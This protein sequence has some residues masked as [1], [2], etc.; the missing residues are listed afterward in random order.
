MEADKKNYSEE[1]EIDINV[2]GGSFK[3]IIMIHL[4]RIA[5]LSSTELRGGYFSV[6]QTKD[7]STKEIYVADSRES[8]SNA[9]YFLAQALF[10]K[11]DTNMETAFKT[12]REA[13]KE[14]KDDFLKATEKDDKEVLGESY[15]PE[16]EK[17]LLE[18]Y[19]IMKLDLYRELFTDLSQFLSRKRYLEMTGGGF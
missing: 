15:Y 8:L 16:K 4:S 9:I 17:S 3:E 5:L 6:T 7:G 14:L 11:F 13:T 1:S 19:K 2:K 10:P 18:T 12:F